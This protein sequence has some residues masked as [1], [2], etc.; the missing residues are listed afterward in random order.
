M[1]LY[2]K[3][4]SESLEFDF[5]LQRVAQ[6][7]ATPGGRKRVLAL[8]P[9]ASR[10]S[11]TPELTK[12]NELLAIYQSKRSVPALGFEP[13]EEPLS[14]LHIKNAVLEAQQFMDIKALA[15]T[16]QNIYLFVANHRELLPNVYGLFWE[17]KPNKI[18]I[19]EIDSV[20]ERNGQV[21]SNASP[22]LAKIRQQLLRKRASA[23][24]IFY[25]ALK[26]YNEQGLLGEFTESVNE[27]RRV[28]AVQSAYKGRVNGLFHGSSAKNSLVFIEPGE[29]IEIN[30]EISILIDDE[31]K[32]IR[33]ILRQL[34]ATLA[35]FKPELVA[36]N[37][38]LQEFD[39]LHARSLYAFREDCALPKLA[40]KPMLKLRE[41]YNPVLRHFHRD[42]QKP[43][44][45]L[46]LHLDTD[47]RIL[48]ISGPNAG[49]K[50]ITLKTVGL[51]QMM[52]QAGMLVPVH[53]DS[54]MG[55]FNTLL[56]DI[57]DS[58]SIENELSTYSSK[59][60]NMRVFLQKANAST[61]FLID[62][63]G[64]GSDP[65]LG[66]ALACVFLETLNERKS[67]GVITTHYNSIKALAA[68]LPGVIN[69][70]MLF[71][72]ATFSPE[73]HLVTGNPGSSYT[74]EV[75]ERN[76]IPRTMI[77]EAK[78]R[79]DERTV[80]MDRLLVSIE[81]QKNKARK[82]KEKTESE[83]RRLR[84][85][86]NQRQQK[87]DQLEDKLQKHATLNAESSKVL[88]WGKRFESL[89]EGWMKAGSSKDRKEVI[90]RFVEMLKSRSGE[91]GRE[92]KK[93]E[94]KRSKKQAAILK[95]KLKEEIAVGDM[96]KLVD[97]HQKGEVIGIKNGKYEVRFGNLLSIADREKIIKA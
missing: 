77:E 47:K 69:G 65:D 74:F 66:A 8:A 49:G 50:S 36:F 58:Q 87:I 63:F 82:N 54:E 13:V 94:K 43:V 19:G 46:D 72:K 86:E 88:M 2:P 29:C 15:E 4:I 6:H 93:E 24:R 1:N 14:I 11:V 61:L 41:A 52:L 96:V 56:G 75:A 5:V 12:V 85:L 18:V 23:D 22:D 38:I 53:P 60:A 3:G 76:G 42:K 73:F 7:T 20:L 84:D 33:R 62:E 95:E 31:K 78:Q 81:S 68:E 57:G 17:M 9:H 26:K 59:L 51:L 64:S 97:S 79:L 35:G 39:C 10:E 30:N 25:R 71:N 34:T 91:K 89:V 37:Q 83:L 45:P 32:E 21:R 16:Y 28:L 48:V 44:I 67:F 55:F 27:D 80:R 70:N 90:G 92:L 40:N